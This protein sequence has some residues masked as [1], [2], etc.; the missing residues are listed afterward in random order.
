MAMLARHV[1]AGLSALVLLLAGCEQGGLVVL[2][3]Q[4]PLRGSCELSQTATGDLVP[5]GTFDLVLGDR[6]SYLLTP[7]VRNGLG[8][9]VAIARAH[10]SID[11]EVDGALVP[12]ILGSTGTGTVYREWD[13]ELDACL[14]ECPVVPASGTASFE[15]PVLPRAVTQFLAT[16]M[17]EAV[18]DGRAPPEYRLVVNAVLV[19]TSGGAEVRSA[20]FEVE[21]RLCLGCLVT[22]PPETDSPSVAG[23]DCCGAGAPEPSCLPGQDDAVDCRDCIRTLPEICNFGRLSCG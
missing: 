23:P 4:R 10:V 19:G 16:S 9:A 12:F 11:W 15:V 14:V 21:V 2:G 1:P 3:N 22:F 17:D 6:S 7:L 8:S 18:L 5:T 20:P 13:V